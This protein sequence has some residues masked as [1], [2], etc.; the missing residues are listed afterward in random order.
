MIPRLIGILSLNTDHLPAVL[1][2]SWPEDLLRKNP[3]AKLSNQQ[4]CHIIPAQDKCHKTYVHC[5]LSV[6]KTMNP[7]ALPGFSRLLSLLTCCLLHL[8]P[9]P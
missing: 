8:V 4:V 9:V 6:D 2:S 1:S 3:S 7:L 5:L